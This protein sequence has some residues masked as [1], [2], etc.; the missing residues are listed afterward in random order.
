MIW[1][2]KTNNKRSIDS[3]D[4]NSYILVKTTDRCAELATDLSDLHEMQQNPTFTYTDVEPWHFY[5]LILPEC[6]SYYVQ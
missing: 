2:G 5:H 3:S 1:N 4:V 6:I